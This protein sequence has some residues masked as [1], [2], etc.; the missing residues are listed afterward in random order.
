MGFVRKNISITDAQD[1]F[2][3]ERNISLSKLVQRSI[4]K[5]IEDLKFAMLTRKNDEEMQKGEYEEMELD[6]LT[7]EAKNWSQ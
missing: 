1:A 7:E 3:R 2:L 6:A 5:E 4:E